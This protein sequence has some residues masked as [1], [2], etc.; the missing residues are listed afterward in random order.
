MCQIGMRPTSDSEVTTFSDS[1][2]F[3]GDDG[4]SFANLTNVDSELVTHP[5]SLCRNVVPDAGGNAIVVPMAFE[6]PQPTSTGYWLDVTTLLCNHS[7][8]IS[9]ENAGTSSFEIEIMSH[10]EG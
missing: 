5:F 6:D 8:I 1:N 4:Y 10:V 9:A 2:E 3:L 7:F